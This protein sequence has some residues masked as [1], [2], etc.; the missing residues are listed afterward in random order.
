MKIIIFYFNIE[1]I[2][3]NNYNDFMKNIIVII[4][5]LLSFGSV[6]SQDL[7]MYHRS[8]DDRLLMPEL[9]VELTFNEFQILSRDI[10]LMDMAASIAFPGYISF[11]A[12]EDT[13]AYISIAVRS[14]GYIGAAFELYRFHDMGVVEFWSDEFDRNMMYA[15]MGIL[16]SSYIFDWLYGKTE[17]EKKQEAIRYKYRH[18]LMRLGES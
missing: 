2:S 12:K 16:I 14:V 7:D 10:K 6:F 13:A 15:T 9:P 5:F 17:L 18:E 11:K 3:K 4:I 1:N 8:M